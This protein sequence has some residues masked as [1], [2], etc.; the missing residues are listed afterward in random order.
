MCSFAEG[1][2]TEEE[3][4]KIRLLMQQA[5][6]SIED[7]KVIEAANKRSEKSGLPAAAIEMNDGTIITSETSDLLG[8][9]AALLLHGI[10][11]LAGLDH[12]VKLIPAE[13]IE[14]IQKTKVKYLRGHNP[15][16]HTDEIL[17]ALSVCAA[18][19][20]KARHAMEQLK[21]LKGTDVH[22]SVMLSSVDTNT[23]RKLGVNLTCEPHYQTKKLYHG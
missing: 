19:D 9:C 2:G 11:Y 6:I 1:K 12:K 10:K 21:N 20:E 16:L 4:N 18:T 23:F 13:M 7:R 22:T 3:V 5:Q 14:P 17:I 8:T 15:R